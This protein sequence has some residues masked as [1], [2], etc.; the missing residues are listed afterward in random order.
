MSKALKAPAFNAQLRRQLRR[1]TMLNAKLVE[2]Q[3]RQVIRSGEFERNANLTV[4][5]K[6][7]TKPLVDQGQ[8]FQFITSKVIDDTTAFVGVLRTDDNYN[9]VQ[10]IHNGANIPVTKRMRGLFFILWQAGQGDFPLDRL[11][12]RAAEL[13]QKM[14]NARYGW[15]PLKD[16]T[17]HIIIPPRPFI[18]EAMDDRKLQLRIKENWVMAVQAALKVRAKE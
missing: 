10:T 8:L 12:G 7:S 14:P 17:T 1:A 15:R 16:S 11:E 4:A 2:R 5:L 3:I 13:F 9:I 6:G 18:H